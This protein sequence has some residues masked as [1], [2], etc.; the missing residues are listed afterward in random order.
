M[1]RRRLALGAVLL[2]AAHASASAIPIDSLFARQSTC[3][4][5][6]N[7]CRDADLPDNFCCPS[8]Q[9]CIVLAGKTTVL[10][11]PEGSDCRRIQ[12]LPCNIDLQDAERHPEAVVKTTALD[13]IMEQCADQC[14]PFGYTCSNDECIMDEDQTAPPSETTT[15]PATTRTTSTSPST[16]ATSATTTSTT[17]DAT[18]VTDS[19]STTD[20]PNETR[21]SSSG[22]PIAAIAGGAV[23]GAI[24][25]IVAAI[26]AFIFYKK[27]KEREA[28]SPPKLSRSTSSFGNIISGPIMAENATVR[29][30]FARV[31]GPREPAEDPGSV[32]ADL[33]DSSMSTPDSA[34][35]MAAPPPAAHRAARQSSV[36]YGYGGPE[37]AAFQPSPFADMP[38]YDYGHGDGALRPETPPRQGRE[39]SSVSINVFADPAIT[40]EG[41]PDSRGNRR[42]SDMTTFTQM[43]DRADLGSVARGESYVPYPHD[44]EQPPMPRR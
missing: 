25:L 28:R 11:C 9:N 18:D 42:Y 15:R 33:L 7:Q 17:S 16:S 31:P 29:T 36:A 37:L 40:P 5:D 19:P 14:C 1:S 30:D 24:L 3:A 27:K 21:R 12:P 43:M 6:F 4:P 8:D 22:L 26:I 10:C 13:G 41:S 20:G 23:G 2:A 44:G 34:A 32:T 38:H 35:M 39:P